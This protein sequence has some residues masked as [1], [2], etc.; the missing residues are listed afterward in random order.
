MR[1][2]VVMAGAGHAGGR[3]ALALRA[4]GYA[5]RIVMVGE[6][7][8]APYERPVLSKGALKGEAFGA[9]LTPS[10]T[11]AAQGIEHLASVSVT[12]L[13]RSAQT[14]SLS[15]GHHLPY[16]HLVL[17]TGG[18]A[19]PLNLPG[20]DLP[21]LH[22]LRT[23]DDAAQL[24]PSLQAGRRLL[25]V[26]GGFI[27]LEVAATARDLGLEVTVVEAAPR[28][29]GRAVPEDLAARLQAT[30]QARGVQVVLG[31]MPQSLSLREGVYTLTL[32]ERVIDADLVVVGIGLVP[33]VELA[34]AAGLPCDNGV[35]VNA[36]LQ[37]ADPNILAVGDVARFP[38]AQGWVRMESWQNAEVHAQV[39]ADVILGRADVQVAYTPWFWS[40]QFDHQLQLAGQTAA[41]AQVVQRLV[42]P[43]AVISFYL[44]TQGVVR[45]MGGWGP[46]SEVAKEL[47]LARV[48]VER[49]ARPDLAAL[50]DPAV[51]LKSLL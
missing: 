8:H 19:R 34:Q 11:W 46:M 26:G 12:A 49:A 15:D 30:H 48:L 5:G 4:G 7:A 33:N 17:A 50:A 40:D 2:T 39:A 21:G 20:A 37:T 51:K 25:V 47:K 45:G 22:A 29:L 44:D 31:Q 14:V 27:G 35:L 6:E 1:P 13:D 16:T 42:S 36:Q 32:P 23:L 43:Q 24:Q 10:D 3:C 28:L 38:T 9:W 18:R 41:A